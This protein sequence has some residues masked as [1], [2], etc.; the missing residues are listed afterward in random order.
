MPVS[1]SS[2]AMPLLFFETIQKA[3]EQ[4]ANFFS[5]QR[6]SLSTFH[7]RRKKRKTGQA[8]DMKSGGGKEWGESKLARLEGRKDDDESIVVNIYSPPPSTENVPRAL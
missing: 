8:A 7:L 2:A 1:S 6:N 5:L 4:K 3:S